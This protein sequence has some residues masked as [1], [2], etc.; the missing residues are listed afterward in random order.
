MVLVISPRTAHL[1][2]M[3]QTI[4][5]G[6]VT[7]LCARPIEQ[8]HRPVLF[9]HGYFA[10]A[11]VWASWLEFFAARGTPAYAVHLRGRAGSGADTTLGSASIN[12][13]VDDAAAVARHAGAG[14]VVGHSM[15][16]L[17]AQKLAERNDVAAAVLITPAPP[18]GI[19]VLSLRV[20]ARQVRY[21]P[22]L[23]LSR[24]VHPGR[25]DL[26]EL[27]MNCVPAERQDALLDLMVP[28]SGRAGREMSITGVAVDR[29][30]VRCPLLVIT[31]DEDRF[32]PAVVV[33]R[34]ARRYDTVCESM[35]NHG[36]MIIVE[37]SWEL[38]AA[39]VEEWIAARE[40]PP[41]T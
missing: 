29:D 31:A 38:L 18:R 22:S 10:D 25:D 24:V 41:V 26:R 35:P 21:L 17:I 11:S 34:I 16:G 20:A 28:D 14:T 13:F 37:P 6:Q 1:T 4:R 36:H 9:V 32:I 2:P 5:V 23:L 3:I 7:A 30:R 12:D 15:G 27:V 40:R 8:R 33:A 39:R 19:S